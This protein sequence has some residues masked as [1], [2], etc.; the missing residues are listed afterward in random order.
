MSLAGQRIDARRYQ[1]VPRVLI[2]AFRD[3]RVLLQ[4]IPERRGAWSGLWN[5]VGGHVEQGESAADAAR[6][7]FLEETGLMPSGLRLA[8]TVIVD[9]GSSPGIGISVFTADVGEGAATSAAEGE[10]RWFSLEQAASLPTV[11]DLPTLLPRLAHFLEGPPPF[12][13][14]YSYNA[15]GQ[16][17]IRIDG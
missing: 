4:R 12:S 9:V 5:G 7:E 16:L 13:A 3:G 14:V 17:S 2:F 11:E 15:S 1:L 8:G 6:R 10:L